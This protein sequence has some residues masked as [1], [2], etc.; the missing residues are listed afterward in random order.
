MVLTG[1]AAQIE[2]IEE[3]AEEIFGLKAWIGRPA[4]V[5]GRAGSRSS[6]AA[7]PPP[8]GSFSSPAA[9]AAQL[10]AEHGGAALTSGRPA[11]AIGS[12]RTS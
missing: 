3:L 1:G 11:S 12:S 2:G 4:A 10:E 6:P 7:A 8:A 9:M 5:R